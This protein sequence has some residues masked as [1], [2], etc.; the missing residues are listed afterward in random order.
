MSFVRRSENGSESSAHCLVRISGRFGPRV[1][2]SYLG[3][4]RSGGWYPT[5][6]PYRTEL[7]RDKIEVFDLTKVGAAGAH[8]RAFDEITSVM[9]MIEQRFSQGQTLTDRR[10]KLTNQIEDAN[11][12]GK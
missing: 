7:A 10:P 6:E 4:C 9:G 1:V 8:G 5:Q 12:T 2:E 3:R 11:T